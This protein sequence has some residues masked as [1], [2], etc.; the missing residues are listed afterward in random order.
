MLRL[1]LEFLFAVNF[2][3]DNKQSIYLISPH[4]AYFL[5]VVVVICLTK[6][7]AQSNSNKNTHTHTHTRRRD[8]RKYQWNVNTTRHEQ[9]QLKLI[10]IN[11]KA[12][13]ILIDELGA[14]TLFVIVR[15]QFF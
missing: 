4:Y 13:H 11:Q 8:K 9:K 2:L 7:A 5:L 3:Q 10:E 14:R 1:F 15:R 12:T 6:N